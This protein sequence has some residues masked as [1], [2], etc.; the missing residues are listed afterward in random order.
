VGVLGRAKLEFRPAGCVGIIL[1]GHWATKALLE[2]VLKGKVCPCDVGGK[3]NPVSGAIQ[4]AGS[5]DT[6]G[7]RYVIAI[8]LGHHRND[9]VDNRLRIRRVSGTLNPLRK[10]TLGANQ[11]SRDLGS[12][13]VNSAGIHGGTV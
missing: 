6:N 2:N 10:L 4:E 13:D 3:V 1:K 5:R 7:A 12:T 9:G 11:T 8:Q